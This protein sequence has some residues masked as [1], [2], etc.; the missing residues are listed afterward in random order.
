[1]HGKLQG[2]LGDPQASLDKA[3]AKK[4]AALGPVTEKLDALPVSAPEAAEP[5]A[6]AP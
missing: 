3:A 6:K 2:L 4:P 1:M 5:A